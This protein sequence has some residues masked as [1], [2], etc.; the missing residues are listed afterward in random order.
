MRRCTRGVAPTF[1]HDLH[2][3]GTPPAFVLSQDQ[4]LQLKVSR[5]RKLRLRTSRTDNGSVTSLQLITSTLALTGTSRTALPSSFQ[6]PTALGGTGFICEHPKA[7]N[8]SRGV[9]SLVN[10]TLLHSP[11]PRCGPRGTTTRQVPPTRELG[12]R[13]ISQAPTSSHIQ[14]VESAILSHDPSDTPCRSIKSQMRTNHPAVG[15]WRRSVSDEGALRSSVDRAAE[16]IRSDV[17]ALGRGCT[18]TG[19]YEDSRAA[20]A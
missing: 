13:G 11:H 3:L 8:P 19:K 20:D 18:R 7:V 5:A 17:T 6:R 15:G 14:R 10:S 9:F 12:P 2:V 4:T 1:P 16:R